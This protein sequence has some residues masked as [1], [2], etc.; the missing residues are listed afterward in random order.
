MDKVGRDGII[1]VD[2]SNGFDNE[3]EISEGMQYEVKVMYLYIYGFWS[4]KMQVEL[5]NPYVLVTNYKI[6]NIQEILP[7]TEP[8]IVQL[9]N[10][11]W[12]LLKILKMKLFRH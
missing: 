8:S 11:Y 1:N 9:I 6:N 2:E 3:L 7:D 12:Q 5:E 4:W 10:H